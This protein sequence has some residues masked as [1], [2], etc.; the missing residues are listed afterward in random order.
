MS[1]SKDFFL[2]LNKFKHVILTDCPN[3][4]YFFLTRK[5]V[6][7][8]YL[9]YNQSKNFALNFLYKELIKLQT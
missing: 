2:F 6:K 4:T 8:N 3:E 9:F 5:K 7:Y 1:S